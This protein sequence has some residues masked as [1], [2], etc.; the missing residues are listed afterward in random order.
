MKVI[1]AWLKWF[2]KPYPKYY[3]EVAEI[4]TTRVMLDIMAQKFTRGKMGFSGARPVKHQCRVCNKTF[5]TERK[6]ED[7]C[8]IW[9]CYREFHCGGQK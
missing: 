7:T 9:S 5:Y 6:L 4:D 1:F 8:K 2:W 3:S